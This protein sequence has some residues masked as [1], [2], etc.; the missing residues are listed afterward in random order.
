MEEIKPEL[1]DELLKGY[2]KP[3]DLIGENGLLK[4]LT[5]AVLERALNAELTHHLGYEKHDPAGH[6]SGNSRNGT[7]T[8]TVKGDFG[9]LV[10]ETPRDRNGT[11]EPQIVGKH[12]TRFAGFDDKILSLYSRGMT[13]REIQAHLKEIYGVEVSPT[14]ISEVTDAV[15]EEVKAWQNRPLEPIYGIVYLDAL[16]V[17]MRHEGRVENR[18]VYVAIGVD[19]DGRKDVLGL[20]TSSNEGA[21]FWLAV[22][23]ELKNR[24]VK[25]ILIACVDGLKGFP[26]AIEAV[27]PETRVQLCIV[28]MVRASLHYVNWKDRKRVAADLKAIYRAAT[29]RQAD[30]EL[31]DF[32]GKWGD[33]YQAIGKLWR[34]NWDRVTPLFDFP[35]EVRRIMYTTNA[36]E[37]LHMSLRKII[38]T[39][40]SFPSE[41]AALKLLYLALQNVSAKWDLVQQWKQAL[42]QFELLWGDR[43]KAAFGKAA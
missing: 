27:F 1:I 7:S 3:E 33:R 11:F 4:Q 15:M 28:H 20:W 6:N 18:A 22:L 43:I 23:T 21:K 39:R 14:L 26:Q 41:E 9:E 32:M 34:D 35:A 30:Q 19:L 2:Q 42:N 31:D 17:K 29:E 8:K 36:V 13:T 40:A 25:D 16:F 5:K 12:Q 38:K 10:V 24:G 37:S